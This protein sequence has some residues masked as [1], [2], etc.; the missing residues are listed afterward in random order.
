[1]GIWPCPG[2]PHL[3][4]ESCYIHI[5]DR[6]T[7]ME[8]LPHQVGKQNR[9]TIAVPQF[10]YRQTKILHVHDS[11]S[12]TSPHSPEDGSEWPSLE[13]C[14]IERCPIL[15]CLFDNGALGLLYVYELRTFWASQLLNSRYISTSN[16]PRAFPH[17]KFLHLDLCPRLIHVL[18]PYPQ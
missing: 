18:P 11:M 10:V 9:G 2:V 7:R 1:M 13:W 17:L 8:L 15:D 6:T 12:I 14:R 4:K 3:P 16:A 5:Q